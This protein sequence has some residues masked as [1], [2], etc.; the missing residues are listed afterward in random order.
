M[1]EKLTPITQVAPEPVL[2]EH[3]DDQTNQVGEHQRDKR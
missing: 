1:R 3:A 2:A